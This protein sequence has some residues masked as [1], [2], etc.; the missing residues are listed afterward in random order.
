MYGAVLGLLPSTNVLLSESDSVIR[1][2]IKPDSIIL[3]NSFSIMS[4]KRTTPK[5]FCFS[6]IANL[7]SVNLHIDLENN[8]DNCSSLLVNLHELDIRYVFQLFCCFS[9]K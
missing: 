6:V 1:P 4:S 5:A 2:N 9:V 3:R 8:D 7:E